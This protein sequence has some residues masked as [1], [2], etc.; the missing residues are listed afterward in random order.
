MNA[1]EINPALCTRDGLCV[2]ECPLHLLELKTGAAVPTLVEGA[3][4]RC[5]RC[6]HCVAV[7][8]HQALAM[9]DQKPEDFPPVD[10]A[11]PLDLETAERFLRSRRSIRV[12]QNREIE[13]GKLDKLLDLAR[14]AP[15]GGNSQLIKYLVFSSREQVRD[16]AGEVVAMMRSLGQSNAALSEKYRWPRLIQAWEAGIDGITRNAPVLVCAYAPQAYNLAVVD[17][18]I[19]LTYLDLAAPSLGLG[20]CWAG[21]VMLALAQWPPLQ[22]KLALPEGQVCY[23]AMM[24]GYPKHK[25]YRLPVRQPADVEWR[26]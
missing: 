14:Y 16:V 3:Q 8:P 17:A 1:L 21:Y 24:I 9:L 2:A 7:C 18:T 13:K 12:Y 15:T 23:G 4:A 19:A 10:P 26:G 25:Y 20:T 5:L 6:G 22:Q 11:A